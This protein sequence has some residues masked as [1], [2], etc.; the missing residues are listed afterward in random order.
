[1][2]KLNFQ[3]ISGAAECAALAGWLYRYVL[4]LARLQSVNLCEKSVLCSESL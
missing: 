4:V 3:L 1:M 2:C